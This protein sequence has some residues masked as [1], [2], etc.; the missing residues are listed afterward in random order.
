MTR[1]RNPYHGLTSPHYWRS[2]VVDIAPGEFDPLVEPKFQLTHKDRVATMGSCFAQH[3]SKF[4][5]QRGLNY[6]VREPFRSSDE[7]LGVTPALSEQFSARYGNV[8][9]VRQAL[10]LFDRVNGWRPQEEYWERDGRYFD[11]FRPTMF[12]AGF[13]SISDL[14]RERQSH[15]E[16]VRDVFQTADIVVFTLGLTETWKSRRDGAVFPV[17]P[18]VVAGSFDDS[19]HEFENFVYGDVT[20]DLMEWCRRVREFNPRVKVLLTVSPVPLNATYMNQN[21]WTSTT[22]SKAVLR[23]AAGDVARDLDYV[24]Y[25]P[26]YEVITCPQNQLRYFED[27]MRNVR[28]VGVQHVMRVF[29][30][31]YIPNES[32]TSGWSAPPV[33]VATDGVAQVICDENLLDSN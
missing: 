21:V 29:E 13:A 11:A 26:S 33:S 5:K 2:G 28:D 12:P 7:I 3:L 17:A 24:D 31:H 32:R 27:D 1:P 9:T 8:Y 6:V 15:L 25:F 14:I 22:Y 30:R 10:Q 4:I 18:G 19:L 23:A 20:S 16:H